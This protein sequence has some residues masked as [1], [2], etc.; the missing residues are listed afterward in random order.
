MAEKRP[1]PNTRYAQEWLE[2]TWE[3]FAGENTAFRPETVAGNGE[4]RS[5]QNMDHF[6]EKQTLAKVPGCVAV[7]A[8]HGSPIRSLHYFERVDRDYQQRRSLLTL[9]DDG[10]LREVDVDSGAVR[11]RYSGLEPERLVGVRH[12]GRYF[13]T[14]TNQRG[15]PTGGL[16]VD[17]TMAGAWGLLGPSDNETVVVPWDGSLFG[18][19][20]TAGDI[21]LSEN[22]AVTKHTT[23]GLSVAKTTGIETLQQV[24]YNTAATDLTNLVESDVLYQWVY[25]PVE[26]FRELSS[27]S[28]AVFFVLT[29]AS[30]TASSSYFFSMGELSPGWQ[31]LSFVLTAPDSTAGGGVDLT[32]VE[33][34]KFCF[35]LKVS[36]SRM[37][38]LVLSKLFGYLP[39]AP[40]VADDGAGSV[41]GDV[42][43]RVLYVRSDGQKSNGGSASE[44][45]TVTSR[46]VSVVPPAS[47]D[48]DVVARWIYRDLDGDALFKF[49]GSIDNNEAGQEFIDNVPYASLGEPDMPLAGQDGLDSSPP[50]RMLAVVVHENRILGIDAENPTTLVLGEVG[51]SESFRI[52]DRLSVEEQ[53]TG[54]ARHAF[55]T[56]L[57]SESKTLILTGDGESNPLV[58]TDVTGEV[59]ANNAHATLRIRNDV[60]TLSE[61]ELYFMANPADPV[62][63][64]EK[65]SDQFI[66]LG[67]DLASMELMHDRARRRLL[68]LVPGSTTLRYFQ[69]GGTGEGLQLQDG[70]WG[71]IVLPSA[72]VPTCME[73]GRREDRTPELWFAA[74][75]GFVY[76]LQAPGEVDYDPG[77]GLPL[78]VESSFRT[79][80][81]PLGDQPSA[82]GTP[83]FLSVSGYADVASTWTVTVRLF[84]G[85]G[86]REIASKSRTFVLGPGGAAPMI[87]LP[88]IGLAAEYADLE[89]T[90]SNPGEGGRFRSVTL[91]SEPRARMRGPA[92]R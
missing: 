84:T 29:S 34:I 77:D 18:S 8:D 35:R 43:Y 21:T 81:R 80:V 16:R 74:E 10:V 91:L 47:P 12:L 90:N 82:T 79:H 54:L 68:C 32:A 53:L 63:M 4:L 17:G 85:I 87:R 86:G 71:K 7:S 23:S 57:F 24:I 49:A 58:V 6:D 76:Q 44:T 73:A 13:L 67:A 38:G 30:D 42:S 1:N 61:A 60:V 27:S 20:G 19:Y 66:A 72:L 83:R 31:L 70:R 26:L 62:L 40:T 64:N 39:G 45:L 51:E 3:L 14:S 41:S 28:S 78:A 48:P 5:I 52:L 9:A 2:R 37:E 75:D 50:P 59:G 89:F 33:Q 46:Q 25:F 65:V 22:E 11:E 56:L 15:L 36:T 92:R 55:G 88:R 69:F